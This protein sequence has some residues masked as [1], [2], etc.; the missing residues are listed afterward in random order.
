MSDM[1]NIKSN[2]ASQK[3]YA[4]SDVLTELPEIIERYKKEMSPDLVIDW[5][6]LALQDND[7]N[8]ENMS[9]EQLGDYVNNVLPVLEER[10]KSYKN[11]IPMKE[12]PVL[13]GF[14]WSLGIGI[15]LFC[16]VMSTFISFFYYDPEKETDLIRWGYNFAS[17]FTCFSPFIF[18]LGFVLLPR[19][20]N[21]IKL[22]N[23]EMLL[24]KDISSL[25]FVKDEITNIRDKT[26][27]SKLRL[28]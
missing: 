23:L 12:I 14:G 13:P 22:S 27:K 19:M 3:L 21:D 16:I 5:N 18:F 24:V 6:R 7:Q 1:K 28:R 4:F 9:L 2:K 8:L 15:L 25:I 10:S 17:C 20:Y 26:R 11:Y